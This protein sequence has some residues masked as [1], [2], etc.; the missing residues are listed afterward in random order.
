[1]TLQHI[2]PIDVT[3]IAS[4]EDPAALLKQARDGIAAAERLVQTV[5]F[6]SKFTTELWDDRAKRWRYDGGSDQTIWIENVPG[7]RYRDD[8][9]SEVDELHNGPSP[10]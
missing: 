7:G 1:M 10:F 4:T 8:V 5:S 6:S 9:I 2:A 3:P